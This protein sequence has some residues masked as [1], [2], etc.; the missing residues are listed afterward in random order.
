M[1]VSKFL[2]FKNLSCFPY[3][4]HGIFDKTWGNIDFRFGG[5]KEVEKTRQKISQ[6]LSI[7]LKN[8]C[9]MDQVHGSK[10][11]VLD[12]Q[13]TRILDN[14]M[15]KATDGLITDRP[16]VF[17]MIKTA[18]CFPVLLF[19]PKQKVVAVVHV[20]WR[21]AMGK[22]FFN[23][24]LRMINQFRCQVKDIL[25]GVGPGIDSCCFQHKNPVQNKL[26]EWQ[27]YIKNL[28]NGFKSLNLLN[29]I[30]DQLIEAGI[31]KQN[32]EAMGLCTSCE[33]R[34]FSHFHSLQT[35]ENEGRFSTIIGLRN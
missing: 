15:I 30:E 26:A 31:K 18:D 6:A 29:F 16:N 20:G 13:S 2:Q 17:L 34:F 25:V 9:E 7:D 11:R 12:S 5:K 33:P 1:V 19:D 14:K 8:L 3:L 28:K 35:G 22:I 32:I 21:G 4:I 24:I 10:I 27:P 23:A